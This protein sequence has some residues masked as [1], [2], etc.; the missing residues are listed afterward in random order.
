[1]DLIIAQEGTTFLIVDMQYCNGFYNYHMFCV[2]TVLIFLY[3]EF[4]PSL[5]IFIV[6]CAA[7]KF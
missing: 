5:F 7:I 4:V 3:V 6:L 2:I 1:M